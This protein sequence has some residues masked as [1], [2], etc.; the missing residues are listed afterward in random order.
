[1]DDMRTFSWCGYEWITQ[2]R[3]GQIHP[4]KTHW[5]Y[6]ESCCEVDDQN[7]LHLTTKFNPKY[8]ESLDVT[9]N[10][11]V[12]LVSCKDKFKQGIYTIEAKLP[13]G[14]NL[15]P[16]FWMWSWDSW[17]P[18]IDVFE[19]YSNNN[20]N[21]FKF[22][23]T[24]PFGF[25]NVQT[26]LHYSSNRGNS[27]IG[28]KTHYFGFKDPTSHF[29]KYSVVWEFKSIKIYYDGKLVRT[30]NDEKIMKQFENTTMNVIINNGVTENV[31]KNNPPESDFIIKSFKFEN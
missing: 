8:F 11:G 17:P 20:P 16:A 7:Q 12:G 19:G 14:K 13:Y 2:E 18:E 26:N 15:W 22:R 5:W 23:M 30:I 3:W 28:G 31:N 29:I 4:E 27:M 25:W 21:Y 9:S 24:N 6:D 10:I 1:M